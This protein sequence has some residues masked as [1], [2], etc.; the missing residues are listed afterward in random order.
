MIRV[1]DTIRE[2]CHQA[3]KSAQFSQGPTVAPAVM[4]RLIVPGRGCALAPYYYDQYQGGACVSGVLWHAVFG[5]TG[6]PI[7]RLPDFAGHDNLDGFLD[8]D[9]LFVDVG[10]HQR[11]AEL[12]ERN[13]EP[14]GFRWNRFAIPSES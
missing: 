8:K 13:L 12:P 11:G 10:H 2:K 7:F 5:R 9:G 1:V 4:D 3:F 6:T 14:D